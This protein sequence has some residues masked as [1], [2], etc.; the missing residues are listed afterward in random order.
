MVHRL[1]RAVSKAPVMLCAGVIGAASLGLLGLWIVEQELIARAGERLKFGAI[2]VAHKLDSLLVERIGVLRLLAVAPQLQS[3]D[4]PAMKAYLETILQTYGVYDQLA[5]AD[6]SGHLVASTDTASIGQEVSTKPWFGSV[7]R[8]T[9]I[10]VIEEEQ[11]SRGDGVLSAVLF[12]AAFRKADGAV[13][14]VVL[15]K[16]ERATW[17]TFVVE[18]IEEFQAQ[19]RDYGPVRYR[20]LAE[21]GRVRLGAEPQEEQVGNLR[22]L[23]LLSAV[24]VVGGRSGFVQEEHLTRRVPVITGYASLAAVQGSEGLRWGIL[25][26]ADRQH[27][28]A[29]LRSVLIN[30]T[31]AG[32]GGFLLMLSLVVWA[33]RCQLR[34]QDHSVKAE[35][36]L[37]E[38][39]VQFRAV[40]DEALDAVVVID[41][42]GVVQFWS[43]Q[44]EHTFGWRATE[45]LG[46]NLAPFIIPPAFREAHQQGMARYLTTGEESVLKKRI[47]IT[48]L[49]R[50]G[51]EFPV[52]LTITPVRAE[53]EVRFSAF[54]RDITERVRTEQR[55]RV[56]IAL[57]MLLS[58][59]TLNGEGR[60][61]MLAAIGGSLQWAAGVWWSPD[62]TNRLHCRAI[63][64]ADPA[65]N[66]EFLKI[67]HGL[68]FGPGIGLPGRVWESGEPAWISA[69]GKT[70][71]FP[72]APSAAAGEI[73]GALAIPIPF[74]G[75]VGGVLEFFS[76]QAKEPDESLLAILAWIGQQIGSAMERQQA[77]QA[78]QES[79][80][81]MRAIVHGAMDAII[82]MDS[83]GR[84]SGWNQKAEEIFGWTEQEA[85]GR[86]LAETIVPPSLREAHRMGLAKYLATGVGPV[87]NQMVEIIGARRDGSEFPVEL[88]ITP[89]ALDSG[90]MFS[91][92]VRDITVRKQMVERLNERETYFRL[93]SEQL[94]VGVFEVRV[95]GS[96]LYVNKTGGTI[97]RLPEAPEGRGHVLPECHWVEWFHQDDHKVLR[98]A[99]GAA[100]TLASPIQQECRLA[101]DEEEPRWVQVLMWPIANERGH[102]YLG[103][104]EDI[105]ARKRTIAHTMQLLRQGQFELRTMAEARNLAELL[106]YAFPDPSRTQLG[107]TELLVN[108]VEHGNLGISYDEKSTLLDQGRFEAELIRRSALPEHRDKRVHITVERTDRNLEMTI[109]DDGS[110]FDWRQYL[111]LDHRRADE[112]HGRGIAMAKAVSF[113][114]LDF[115]GSGN[116]VVVSVSLNGVDADADAW[117]EEERRVA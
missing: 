28:L 54:L 92:F 19:T 51:T 111:D 40:L 83:S 3:G 26:R 102:R 21:D 85:V 18:T 81:R 33:K 78:R 37:A 50:D 68:D 9:G 27:V 116:Q 30:V 59:E 101:G 79:D 6:L 99:W 69:A 97:L 98:E 66:D 60:Q 77:E 49:R 67:T 95:D 12:A 46:K 104:M 75:G 39:E 105:T 74:R 25:V 14:G 82:V 29:D 7:L 58:A 109:L 43:K 96:C 62:S 13:G 93:L 71:T 34:E 76:N 110:G 48:A 115:Q 84:I 32:A 36:A 63:W 52:E 88:T 106:A 86:D 15:A 24:H 5:V 61:K 80:S 70:E 113:D 55:K 73:H 53:S 22:Q 42:R 23:G 65:K 1:R 100:I 44:A 114:Q 16:V 2:Q 72:R 64:A 87:L 20:I 108:G 4:G 107:L 35:Q 94:P 57:N 117:P 91:A 90:R 41:Q 56:Q 89:L 8:A 17:E 10:H 31:A 38:S 112:S 103:T 11:Q 45:I 47:E